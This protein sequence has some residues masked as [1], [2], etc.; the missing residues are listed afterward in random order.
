MTVTYS[1]VKAEEFEAS[2]R[3]ADAGLAH[4]DQSRLSRN[5]ARLLLAD[6]EDVPL[7]EQDVLPSLA[8]ANH[9]RASTVS[10]L[11]H[12]AGRPD[13]VLRYLVPKFPEII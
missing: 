6:R 8:R 12:A 9:G 10:W 7:P 13:D 2:L 11:P 4:T 5:D 1:A 3:Q